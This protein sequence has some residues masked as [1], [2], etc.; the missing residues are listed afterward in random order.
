M[1]LADWLMSCFFFGVL[2]VGVFPSVSRS[3]GLLHGQQHALMMNVP[4]YA[5]CN[6]FALPK[7][8]CLTFS[9]RQHFTRIFCHRVRCCRIA[10]QA[11]LLMK[12]A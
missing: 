6:L 7:P 8:S 9:L 12:R 2:V 4:V 1:D 5:P 11:E 10:F 3:G